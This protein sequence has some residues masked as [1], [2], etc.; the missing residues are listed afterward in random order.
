MTHRTRYFAFRTFPVLVAILAF[1]SPSLAGCMLPPAPSKVPQA[2]TA[3]DTEMREAMQT[4]KR[5]DKDVETY[6]KCL[7]FEVRQG[8]LSAEEGARLHNAAIE[9]LQKVV[10]QFN[11]QMRIFLGH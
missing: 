4:M 10:A 5:Y 3:T 9:R 11:E 2:D 6:T 1:S 8:R 7:A